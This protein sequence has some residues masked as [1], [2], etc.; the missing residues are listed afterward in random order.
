VSPLYHYAGPADLLQRWAG[1]PRGHAVRS[2][3]DLTAWLAGRPEAWATFVVDA[4]GVLLLADRRSEH[5]ACAG[6][7]P[8]R[9]AGEMLL[10]PGTIREVSNLSTGYCPP[11]SCWP[12]VAAAATAALLTHPGGFTQA[13][14]FR[15]CGACGQR[16]VVKDGWLVCGVCGAALPAEWNFGT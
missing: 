14:E 6:G 2:P 1:L 3:A 8:V 7:C 11:V 12:A 16:N 4:A 5:V 9:A 10:A 15:H 13:I